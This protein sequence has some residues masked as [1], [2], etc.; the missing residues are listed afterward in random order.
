MSVIF[1]STTPHLR[2]VTFPMVAETHRD[3][4]WEVS[5]IAVS[6]N[7]NVATNFSTPSPSSLLNADRQMK[8]IQQAL[9]LQHVITHTKSTVEQIKFVS[10]HAM[11][12]GLTTEA[13]LH[14]FPALA[15]GRGGWSVSDP[16]SFKSQEMY[17][18]V[19]ELYHIFV[20]V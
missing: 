3:H 4:L 2:S 13:Q 17:N 5:V 19:Q 18:S 15:L 20:H 7:W 10:V 11:K 12:Y 9:F 8:W 14:S 6:Q 16:S 1:V